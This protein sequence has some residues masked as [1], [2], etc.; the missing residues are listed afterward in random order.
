VPT[1]EDPS[2]AREQRRARAREAAAAASPERI[3][4]LRAEH[5]QDTA[6]DQRQRSGISRPRKHAGP[7]RPID[8]SEVAAIARRALDDHPST[9]TSYAELCSASELDRG[10]ALVVARLLIPEPTGEH[11]FR[12]RNSDGVYN[13]PADEA[14]HGDPVR[15]S[16]GEA[17]KQLARIGVRVV[18]K[19]AD[20]AR[21]LCWTSDGWVIGG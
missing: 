17:D 12:I 6:T 4:E 1:P 8:A 19:R 16:Q 13:V 3:A 7:S 5:A 14:E 2:F 21:K 10:L 20:R 11:W 9:W 18:A 15:Y